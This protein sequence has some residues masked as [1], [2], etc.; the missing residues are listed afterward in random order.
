MSLKIEMTQVARL[1]PNLLL[2][3]TDLVSQYVSSLI[4]PQGLFPDREGKPDFYYSTFGLLALDALQLNIPQD[5]LRASLEMAPLP[6]DLIEAST[7]ARCWSYVDGT[8]PDRILNAI[9]DMTTACIQQ[10][11]FGTAP[12]SKAAT[13]Y[14]TFLATGLFQDLNIPAPE[15]IDIPVFLSSVQASDG[16][17]PNEKSISMSTSPS[18]AAALALYRSMSIDPP[19]SAC[20]WLLQRFSP[21]GG[22]YAAEGAPLPDLL[23]TAVAL[24]AL[25]GLDIKLNAL[26]E[27]TLD[28]IDSLWTNRGGFYGNWSEDILDV[29]YTYYG[30]LALGHLSVL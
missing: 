2:E 8:A 5:A 22:V 25:N 9:Q 28:F 13:V 20:D 23:S 18:T 27:P 19:D 10:D 1:A 6:E 24:H 11:A 7:L 14:A 21:E 12:D 3:S 26:R 17:F 16:G 15:S 30:L 4:T 29:E